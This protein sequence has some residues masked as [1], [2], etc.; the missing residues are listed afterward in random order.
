MKNKMNALSS[1]LVIIL[2]A[3]ILTGCGSPA[4]TANVIAERPAGPAEKVELVMFHFTSRCYSCNYAEAGI[5]YTLENNFKDE[6]DSG[7]VS[8]TAYD[9][10]DRKNATLVKKYK[11]YGLSL[12]TNTTVG[13]K[14]F[15]EGVTGIWLA[16][17]NDQAFVAA[18]DKLVSAA[19]TGES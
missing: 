10:Q 17:G 2:L 6:M 12:Y 3:A 18:V 5:K 16:V 1:F 14:E 4:S 7:K 15:I 8:F 11:V 9:L 13:G 19:L